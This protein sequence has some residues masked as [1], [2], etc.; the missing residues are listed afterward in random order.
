VLDSC[1]HV[2]ITPV[3]THS[4]HEVNA[5]RTRGRRVGR[6]SRR[7]CCRHPLLQH[8]L[9][10]LL[11]CRP[12]R[13]LHLLLLLLLLLLLELEAARWPCVSGCSCWAVVGW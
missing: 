11:R 1:E 3:V 10:L 6:C 12:R 5:A 2:F 4:Q 7:C 8:C 9:Q 13:L